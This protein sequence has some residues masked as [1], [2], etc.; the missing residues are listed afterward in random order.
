MVPQDA[1]RV[2]IISSQTPFD[3]L[4][5]TFIKD[6]VT[7]APREYLPNNPAGGVTGLSDAG[8]L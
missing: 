2:R 7:L 6:A 8:K 4:I 3:F 5:H 1:V